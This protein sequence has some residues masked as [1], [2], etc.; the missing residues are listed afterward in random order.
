M[1]NLRIGILAALVCGVTQPA[2]ATFSIIARDATT[3]EMGIAVASK[4]L[5]TRTSGSGAESG[6]GVV[7]N[8]ADNNNVRG[9]RAMELLRA[10]RS[11]EEVLE[12][13][14]K[15][16][17]NGTQ[18]IA[19]IDVHGNVTASTGANT[20][21]WKGHRIGN[22]YSVQGNTLVGSQV[23]D[24]MAK[25][26]ESATGT[27]AE[28]LLTALEAG[29]N[30]GG[31][32]RGRQSA[33]LLVVK[34]SRLS[35]GNEHV[36]DLSVDDHATPI[37]EL[38]RL[39]TLSRSRNLFWDSTA[40]YDKG[41]KKAA[42]DLAEAAAKLVPNVLERTYV[43]VLRYDTGDF[44]GALSEFRAARSLNLAE[45]ESWWAVWDLGSLVKDPEFLAKIKAP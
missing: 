15:E 16:Q 24:A 43:G 7:A 25:A 5:A 11:A 34:G 1:G 33:Y 8:Q 13:L 42:L 32:K 4:Y 17:T 31:D 6:A 26:F 18:Q 44:A 22:G 37:P 9:R 19:I 45:F 2:F 36:H 23:L 35:E 29:D 27:L 39:L 12:Q 38:R 10:G 28:R 30:A 20:S 14:L 21:D 40:V 3:G 41:D